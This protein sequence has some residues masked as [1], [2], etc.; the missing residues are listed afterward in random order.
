MTG[1]SVSPFA[2]LLCGALLFAATPAH[3]D[4]FSS[5]SFSGD[6]ATMD[7][8]PGV[9]LDFSSNGIITGTSSCVEKQGPA[10][11]TRHGMRSSTVQEC[12]IGNFTFSSGVANSTPKV[13]DETYGGNPP[14]WAAGW[15]PSR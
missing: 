3:A 1:F 9:N 11:E 14:P 13:Y 2:G 10:F 8:L 15:R 4:V 12:T 7:Q 5:Q 6:P